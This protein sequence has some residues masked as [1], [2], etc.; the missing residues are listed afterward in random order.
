VF[1]LRNPGYIKEEA[2]R[3]LPQKPRLYQRRSGTCSSSQTQVIS[4]KKRDVFFIRNPG[5]IKEEAGRVLLQKPM[6]PQA[7][8]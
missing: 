2:G 1:F 4:K 5:Y 8:K 7:V 6:V 3:V